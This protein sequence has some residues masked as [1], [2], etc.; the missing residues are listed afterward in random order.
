[1][2]SLLYIWIRYTNV[3]GP[4]DLA[5]PFSET[6]Y[7]G[8]AGIAQNVT[9]AIALNYVCII[10]CFSDMANKLSVLH[11]TPVMVTQHRTTG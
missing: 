5:T 11:N 4:R 1:M 3:S 9:P 7:A 2:P 10:C 8:S 6:L